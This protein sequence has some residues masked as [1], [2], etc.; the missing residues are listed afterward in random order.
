MFF[1]KGFENID[2]FKYI[3]KY[4]VYIY[5]ELKEIVK[6]KDVVIYEEFV[7]FYLLLFREN[8]GLVFRLVY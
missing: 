7:G 8:L 3:N 5:N 6:N 1:V 4:I 2:I